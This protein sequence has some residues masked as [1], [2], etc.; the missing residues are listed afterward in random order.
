MSRPV[1]EFDP[2]PH[3]YTVNGEK[4]FPTV[5]QIL[6]T[7]IN[8]PF[9]V[10][11]AYKIGVEAV[12][13]MGDE[14]FERFRSE[15]F[16]DALKIAKSVQTTTSIRDAAG[17]RGTAI[18]DALERYAKHG[19]VPLPV[20][21]DEADQPRI[22]GLAKWIVEN[23]PEYLGA[24]VRTA[25]LEH[26]YVGTL[27]AYVRFEKGAYSGKLARID[28][29]TSKSIY[30]ENFVQLEAYEQAEIECGEPESDVRL[31][32]HIPQS[33]NCTL[34]ESTATFHDFACHV[35]LYRSLKDREAREKERKRK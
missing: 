35:A 17:D 21:F 25:S 26:R 13:M 33:G 18:H 12:H 34:H 2:G 4:G 20:D 10:P 6:G 7:T 19:E 14:E 29:K 32:V 5:T 22:T 24:E 23:R 11:W 9:L 1:I 3:T 15:D 31:V 28:Y 16:S 30:P 8:K 27:D